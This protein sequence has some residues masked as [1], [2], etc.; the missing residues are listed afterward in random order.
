MFSREPSPPDKR[1]SSRISDQVRW[2]RRRT[3]PVPLWETLAA[4]ADD[5]S[6]VLQVRRRCL[7]RHSADCNRVCCTLP[8]NRSI[9]P[10]SPLA[11]CGSPTAVLAECGS[12]GANQPASTEFPDRRR[13]CSAPDAVGG[14]IDLLKHS[15]Q[16]PAPANKLR[17]LF[18]TPPMSKNS[19]RYDPRSISAGTPD[20]PA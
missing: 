15:P 3:S 4:L 11:A 20:L 13:R 1:I 9:S 8:W 17:P 19:N 14:E 2:S 12:A 6:S 7:R 10:R 5:A 18:S 16:P